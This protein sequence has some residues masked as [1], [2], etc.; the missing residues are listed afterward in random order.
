MNVCRIFLI[1]LLLFSVK[2]VRSQERKYIHEVELGMGL[3]S[4]NQVL[5]FFTQAVGEELDNAKPIG[6]FRL[7]Y[8][9]NITE[10][11]GLGAMTSFSCLKGDRTRKYHIKIGDYKGYY[12][13]F[14]LEFD[15]K[16]INNKNFKLYSLAG[17]GL[18]YCHEILKLDT[19]EVIKDDL[20]SNDIIPSFQLTPI[21]LKFGQ[22]IGGFLEIGFGYRGII[23]GGAFMRF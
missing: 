15:Y 6:E 14:A 17:I 1:I 3:F 21:G 13:T 23:T 5:Q 22:K 10:K 12:Y 16:F 18:A 11:F 20:L 19:G 9:Y 7:A 8:R 2:L 4:F